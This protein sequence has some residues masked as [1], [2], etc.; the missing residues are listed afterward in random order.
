MNA[1][2]GAYYIEFVQA[3]LD[4]LSSVDPQNLANLLEPLKLCLAKLAPD[5]SQAL[6]ARFDAFLETRDQEIIAAYLRELRLPSPETQKR[7]QETIDHILDQ[8]LNLLEKGLHSSKDLGEDLKV[9]MQKVYKAKSINNLRILTEEVQRVGREIATRNERLHSG[10]GQIAAELSHYRR[11]I[12]D[13]ERELEVK[14]A[15]ADFD[16]LTGLHN[17][18][19]FERDLEDNVTR[20]RRFG[21]SFC[22]LLLDIDHFKDINDIWGHHVGDDVL[23][24]FAKLLNGNLRGHDRSYRL[25]GDEFAVFLDKVDLEQARRVAERLR[26]YIANRP[27]HTQTGRFQITISCGLT[28]ATPGEEARQL[29]ERAD[30]LLYEAKRGGRNMILT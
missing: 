16:H 8:A 24:N 7:I 19:V 13:L 20:V 28:A 2:R 23:V 5:K 29:Y 22:L 30:Q 27:Y 11:Q 14:R 15:E 10:L 25:G 3:M 9:I 26:E 12:Q 1:D 4:R 18:R 6:Q 17:R 21:A